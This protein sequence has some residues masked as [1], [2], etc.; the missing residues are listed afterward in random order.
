MRKPHKRVN[1]VIFITIIAAIALVLGVAILLGRGDR[2]TPG[3]N[4]PKN[5]KEQ[6]V[7]PERNVANFCRFYQEEKDSLVGSDA[8]YEDSLRAFRKLEAVS[9]DEVRADI[10]IIRKGTETLLE[11]PS[12]L[13]DM[14][15]AVLGA[16]GKFSDYVQAHCRDM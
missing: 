5:K 14:S 8:S 9:P 6:S 7:K 1:R 15:M 4:Q 13:G 3:T 2:S 16:S 12:K 10:T 11:D